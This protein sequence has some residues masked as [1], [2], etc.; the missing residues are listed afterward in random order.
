[1][2]AIDPTARLESGYMLR[3][4][5]TNKT[6]TPLDPRTIA[7]V[8]LQERYDIQQ[9]IRKSPDAFFKEMD[10]PLMLIGEEIR[11]AEFVED[12][13]DL[14]AIDKQGASVIIELKRGTHKLH[15]LQALAYA[16][17]VA[18]WEPERIATEHGRTFKC[19]TEDSDEKIEE[20][21]DVETDSLNAAQRVI[22]IAEGFDYE[23]LATA[24][25]LTE[26]YSVDVRCYR[27]GLSADG[28]IEYLTCTCIYPPPEITAHSERRGR[29]AKPS[30][31]KTWEEALSIIVNPAIVEFFQAE[32]NA[33][34]ESYLRNRVLRYRVNDKRRFH[35]SAR[36]KSAY[37]WQSGRFDG[38]EGYWRTKIGSHAKV[39]PVK[40]GSSLRFYLSSTDDFAR[41][42]EAV[43]AH[44]NGVQW[45]SDGDLPE[46][47]AE[48]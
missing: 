30:R 20:F 23:V 19:S 11:P 35:V 24:D 43:N 42:R 1:M 33:K 39:E 37:V 21:L 48:H 15:L 10:E 16:A 36:K 45:L 3:V 12:R 27:I 40:D 44:L 38:D 26:R 9:M 4:D 13:I 8:G 7:E 18:K 5:R 29:E 47:E 25:W 14:F 22:L 32:L 31:W 28:A 6:L 46:E 17:M 2:S 34:R 41:F